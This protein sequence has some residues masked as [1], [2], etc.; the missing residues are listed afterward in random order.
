MNSTNTHISL[1]I[2]HMHTV[3]NREIW[4]IC[5]RYWYAGCAPGIWGLVPLGYVNSPIKHV[6]D[7]SP[8]IRP[9][10]SPPTLNAPSSSR[11]PGFFARS[12]SKHTTEDASYSTPLGLVPTMT[13]IVQRTIL[14]MV[15]THAG[16]VDFHDQGSSGKPGKPTLFPHLRYTYL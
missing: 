16:A 3:H 9:L 8:R 12:R 13:N 7:R 14:S 15:P 1:Y 11:R 4:G 5:K 2:Y 10:L 6:T